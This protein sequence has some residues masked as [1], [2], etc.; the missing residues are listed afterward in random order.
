MHMSANIVTSWIL[1]DVH[2]LCYTVN[3]LKW[4]HIYINLNVLHHYSRTNCMKPGDPNPGPMS[5][6]PLFK[7]Q[8]CT[9]ST[10]CIHLQYLVMNAD[11]KSLYGES[12]R[13]V[14]S[15]R[16]LWITG[17]RRRRLWPNPTR[18]EV[19]QY[20]AMDCGGWDKLVLENQCCWRVVLKTSRQ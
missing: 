6:L 15:L 4:H 3:V 17:E 14:R 1:R 11:S 7:Y 12:D 20:R 18:L 16:N 5:P 9:R 13:W 2:W 8:L 19:N 10:L